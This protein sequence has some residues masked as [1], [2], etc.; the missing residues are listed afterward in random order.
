MQNDPRVEWQRLSETYSQMYDDELLQLAVD[1]DDLTEQAR[2][3]LSDEMKKRRLELPRTAGSA[4]RTADSMLEQG[5]VALGDDGA[6][7]LVSDGAE[8][9]EEGGGQHE[10]T[11]KTAL[12]GC[13]DQEE[14]WQIFEVLRQA[15]I[16][17]WIE[18]PGARQTVTWNEHVVWNLKVQVAADQ[19]DQAR[20]IIANPIPQEIV[21]QSKMRAPEFEAPVCPR[22]GAADPVLEG[23]DPVNTWLCEACDHEW[24]DPEEIGE[25][26]TEEGEK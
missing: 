5:G 15:G 9:G 21:E 20:A 26:G 23:V 24:T 6:P 1:S 18:R 4:R 2:Q 3:V 12:C 14:A 16:E 8:G 19:L 13:E 11:W 22:C 7:E 10:F 17:S 25:G